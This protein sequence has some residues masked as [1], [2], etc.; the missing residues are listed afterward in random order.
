[1][2]NVDWEARRIAF[3]AKAPA[4]LLTEV[5]ERPTLRDFSDE[6]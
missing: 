1:V 4:E 3:E 5:R 6:C 2:R